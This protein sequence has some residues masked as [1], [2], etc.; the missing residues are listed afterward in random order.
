[1]MPCAQPA[2][3]YHATPAELA[4]RFGLR[5]LPVRAVI[6]CGRLPVVRLA[7]RPFVDVRRFASA[8]TGPSG[9]R[10]KGRTKEGPDGVVSVRA[11]ESSDKT[12]AASKDTP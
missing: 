6:L 8:L 1:M 10:D 11:R 9:A 4:T 7:G 5:P 12:L 2:R 3:L